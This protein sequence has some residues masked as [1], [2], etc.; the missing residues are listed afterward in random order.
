VEDTAAHQGD[1]RT[2]TGSQGAAIPKLILAAADAADNRGTPPP[3]L[4]YAWQ[5][6]RWGS[7]P[8]AGG[9]RDQ[10]MRL[11]ADMPVALNVYNARRDYLYAL[12]NANIVTWTQQNKGKWDIIAAI[13]KL[14][15]EQRDNGR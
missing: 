6:Q 11:M 9:L 2:R 3:E 5:C 15:K 14:R 8:N 10:P 12:Q 13:F 4:R 1:Q 7:L